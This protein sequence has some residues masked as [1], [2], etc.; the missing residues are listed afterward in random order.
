MLIDNYDVP[1]TY[2]PS[3]AKQMT[4]NR[5]LVN[6]FQ[7]DQYIVGILTLKMFTCHSLIR[8][9]RQKDPQKFNWLSD[10]YPVLLDILQ[11]NLSKV[12]IATGHMMSNIS[13]SFML[14][15]FNVKESLKCLDPLK[16]AT[17]FDASM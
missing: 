3:E 1:A 10:V 9:I 14:D 15:I 2:C 11:P 4:E 16:R 13:S 6:G 12:L 5:A 8:T 17:M 7:L